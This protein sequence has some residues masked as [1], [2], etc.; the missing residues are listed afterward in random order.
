MKPE[1]NAQKL[2]AKIVSNEEVEKTEIPEGGIRAYIDDEN[3]WVLRKMD[4][5]TWKRVKKML[6][7][8]KD[9][10]SIIW[11]VQ[12]LMVVG[13]RDPQDLADDLDYMLALEE[14]ITSMVNPV[15]I[16]IKKK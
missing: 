14:A 5:L 13:T 6:R 10:E 7:A 16:Q 15:S 8:Q 1:T 9:D 11:A 3:H 4:M 12:R 2:N